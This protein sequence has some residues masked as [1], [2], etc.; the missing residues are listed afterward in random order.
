MYPNFTC[1][2]SGLKRL[3]DFLSHQPVCGRAR[4]QVDYQ[5]GQPFHS[6]LE[7]CGVI[8]KWIPHFSRSFQTVIFPE[9]PILLDTITTIS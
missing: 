5:A 9:V 7:H 6:S 1:R 8:L 4:V 2:K 3:N